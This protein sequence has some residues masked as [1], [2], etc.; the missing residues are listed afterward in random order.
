MSEANDFL[1]LFAPEPEKRTGGQ[2]SQPWKVL[3]VDDEADVHAALRLAL[4]DAVV[5]G[6]R[7]QLLDALSAREAIQ[8][9]A[10]QTDIALVLLDVVMESQQAGLDLVRHIRQNLGNHDIQIVLVTGQPGYAPERE[11]IRDYEIDGYRLKSELTADKIFVSVYSSIRTHRALRELKALQDQL[12]QQAAA[13]TL[14]EISL[15]TRMAKVTASVPNISTHSPS[16]NNSTVITVTSVAEAALAKL[17]HNR[18]TPNNLSVF[19]S[20]ALAN[21][22]PR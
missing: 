18:I 20:S 7:L 4:Q 9:L 19:A 5:E 6:R 17:L 10:G 8:I 13:M 1:S 21:L 11:V 22:A 2:A 3:L 12:T 16:P 14:G 15:K